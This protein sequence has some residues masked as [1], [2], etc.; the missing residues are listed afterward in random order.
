MLPTLLHAQDRITR[1]EYIERY[2][3]I[4]IKNMEK[5]GVPASITMAQGILE[6]GDGNSTLAV[7]GNNHFGI[8]CHRTWTGQRIYHDDDAKG[9]CFRKYRSPEHSFQDH[10]EFLRGGR[11]YAFLFDL[12]PTDYKGW[13]RGLRQA[14][15]A[16]DPR[17][18]ESLIRIIEENSLYLLDR[19]V[20]IKVVSPTKGMG[21]LADAENFRIDI[22]SQREIFTRN[23]IKY[24]KVKQGDTYQ[25]LTRE[26]EMMPWELARYNE[27]ERNA[28]LTPGQELYIQPK[29]RRAEV[30]HS[31]HV[32]EAGETMY[33][34]SQMYG[35]RLS[36]LYRLNR[37]DTDQEVEE[38]QKV[39]LR[40]RKPAGN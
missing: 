18:A 20:D 9:E 21:Q 25:S 5:Y 37:M 26:L 7:K 22:Y 12:E 39:F 29:R 31:H 6:S 23:R 10:S 13:A 35:I 14:G 8:K 3:R 36:S 30:N 28:T 32:A 27:I 15:Y 16:T 1:A 17:Y 2:K 38:G 11:R 24:I 40:R 33:G 34:I 4:A 19:G